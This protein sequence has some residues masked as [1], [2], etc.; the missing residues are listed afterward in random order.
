MNELGVAVWK[1]GREPEAEEVLRRVL[2]IAPD[3][4][5][6]LT[7]LGL[8]LMNGRREAEAADYFRAAI[9]V[10]P[11]AFHAR[12]H[13]G[14]ILSNSGDFDGATEWHES[15]LAIGPDSPVALQN[16]AVNLARQGRWAEA[17]DY[18][19]R[20]VPLQAENAELH[21]NY[22][23]AL[24]ASGRF[25]KGWVEHEWRLNVPGYPGCRIN[26]TFWNGDLF[27]DRTILLH[28]EQGFGDTLQF[29][30]YVPLVK[31][32]GGRVVVLCQQP[33]V[34]L[35]SRCPGVDLA[36]DGI[37]FEPHCDIHAPLMSLPLIFGTTMETIPRAVPYLFPDPGLV[38]HWRSVLARYREDGSVL[39]GIAWQGRPENG[40]DHWRSYPLERMAPLAAVPGVRLISLQVGPGSEQVAELEGRFPVVE[41]PGRRGRD[42]SETAAIASQLDLVVGPCSAMTHLAGGLGVT[43]WLALVRRGTGAGSPTAATARGIPPC[44]SSARDGSAT[45]TACSDG[46]PA[47]WARSSCAGARP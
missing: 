19:G 30:R 47:S 38:E 2:E 17:A 14:S 44:G 5:G 18:Y 9:R 35:L 34:R 33:M 25:E 40:A 43:A 41:L 36:C 21:R 23:F 46:W 37:G 12:M 13:L 31:A 39:V 15:A 10:E 16:M 27:R 11:G 42:F 29:I 45:G 1:Q 32:R 4:F 22:G 3:H 24:L 6:A 26:R 7:N 8:A 28:F 20:A